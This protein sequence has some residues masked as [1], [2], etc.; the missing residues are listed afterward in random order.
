MDAHPDLSVELTSRDHLG[1]LVAEGFD[2]GLRFGEP[3][4]SSLVARKLLD[5]AVVT[6]ASPRYLA[7]FG[8][9]GTPMALETDAHRCLEFRNPETGKPYSWEFH[10]KRKK[11]VVDTRGRLTVNDPSA[12]FDACLAGSGIAQMLQIGAERFIANGELVNLSPD[13][14]D[15]RFPL[16]AYYPSRR[17]RPAKSR[18]FLEFVAGL[19]SSVED[20]KK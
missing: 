16:Y 20:D 3:Q 18:R 10:R 4:S 19:T 9:P 7:R 12:L 2:L 14:P 1:D 8:H 6:V 15:E 11:L 5:T 17:N 13:W